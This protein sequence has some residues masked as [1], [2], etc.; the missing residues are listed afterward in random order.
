[1]I[2]V[3]P[4]LSLICLF[5]LD[6]AHARRQKENKLCAVFMDTRLHSKT[7]LPTTSTAQPGACMHGYTRTHVTGQDK[8]HTLAR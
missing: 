1:M 2:A 4:D 6:E 3:F 7:L 5:S 8:K